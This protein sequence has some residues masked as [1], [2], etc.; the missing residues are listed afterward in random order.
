MKDLEHTIRKAAEIR[1]AIKE[2]KELVVKY[3]NSPFGE[4]RN[5]S[6]IPRARVGGHR[7]SY[8]VHDPNSQ[9][10]FFKMISQKEIIEKYAGYEITVLSCGE[11]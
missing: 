4:F 8:E 2:R 6:L 3:R 10:S 11:L 1:R 7:C 5:V 9:G